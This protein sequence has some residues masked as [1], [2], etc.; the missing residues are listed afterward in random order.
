MEQVDEDRAS[1]D[2]MR[3][4]LCEAFL[5]DFEDTSQLLNVILPTVVDFARRIE[6][7]RPQHFIYSLQA[8]GT[9]TITEGILIND[10][11]IFGDFGYCLC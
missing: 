9:P 6:D 4:D 11:F 1:E 7:C 10:H 8:E 2:E 5:E 3:F